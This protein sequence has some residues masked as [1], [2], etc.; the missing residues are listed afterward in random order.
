MKRHILGILTL[1]ISLAA[2]ATGQDGDVIYINGSEYINGTKWTLLGK[3]IY[4]DSILTKALEA[5]LPKKGYVTSN[6]SGYTAYWSI[7]NNKLYLDNICCDDSPLPSETLH[8]IFRKYM[9]GNRIVATWFT[10]NIRV[11]KGNLV[12]YVHS[13][14]TRNYEEEQIISL[15]KGKVTDVKVFHNY[16]KDGLSF[17][18]FRPSIDIQDPEVRNKLFPIHPERYPDLKGVERI[19]TI[20]MD[21]AVDSTGH[22][23]KC[24]VKATFERNG[25]KVEHPAFAAEIEEQLKAYYPWR[26]YFIN[27]E[28]VSHIKGT[29][30]PFRLYFK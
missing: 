20:V 6:W 5:S 18:N 11:G 16:M 23:V 14:Y 24:K 19:R 13:G 1:F 15:S 30:I 3:P 28:F 2:F 22:L 8:R 17:D 9:D 4:K 27:G 10:G 26:V 21:A 12:Y 29:V 7:A 25:Q